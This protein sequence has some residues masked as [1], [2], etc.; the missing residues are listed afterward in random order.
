M[1]SVTCYNFQHEQYFSRILR[2]SRDIG[3]K[4]TKKCPIF[5]FFEQKTMK[6]AQK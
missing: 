6:L 2:K 3:P 1:H 5:W 4:N